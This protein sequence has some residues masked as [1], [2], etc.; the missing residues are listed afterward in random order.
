M[1]KM[2]R[3][4]QGRR[5][6][7]TLAGFVLAL[8]A[9]TAILVWGAASG[10]VFWANACH[11]CDGDHPAEEAG[12][13]C[14]ELVEKPH[15][16]RILGQM[17]F[18]ESGDTLT[19]CTADI[20]HNALSSSSEKIC[21][22]DD[23]SHPVNCEGSSGPHASSN[24]I[25]H[26]GG[27][28]EAAGKYEWFIDEP[29]LNKFTGA[30]PVAGLECYTV[31]VDSGDWDYQYLTIHLNAGGKSIEGYASR[32]CMKST[33]TPTSTST[34]TKTA[35]P[36]ATST[37]TPTPTNT[38]TPTPTSTFTPTATHTSTPTPT[39][40]FTPTPTETST[41]TPTETST[42]TPTETLTPTPTH[43]S[44]PTPTETLTPTPTETFT[45]TPTETFT[46]TPTDTSTP[47][48][49]E[50]PT[51]TPTETETPRATDTPTPTATGTREATHTP[52]PTEHHHTRTPTP[53]ETE[54]PLPT[55]TQQPTATPTL[56]REV[57][58]AQITRQPAP[59]TE[60][61]PHAGMPGEGT[62]AGTTI[63]GV[64]SSIAG[65]ALLLSGLRLAR[66]QRKGVE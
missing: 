26:A 53:E 1:S 32:F 45:P 50:T 56:F 66:R 51:A 37:H 49:T 23:S 18:N 9:C 52:T 14:A 46:P 6:R 40:T 31:K 29:Y 38:H 33:P 15:P 19:V 7:L 34:P 4:V 65:I 25:T 12:W 13:C 11:A 17:F 27:S 24:T 48:P 61:L 20:D 39:Q 2:L 30:G 21:V 57:V 28:E 35:T 59:R 8:G 10:N 22:D 3:I 36:T 41:P 62:S 55:S 47:T 16:D 54:T 60:S 5:P 44:T 58:P 43:T 63:A 42:P 64:L